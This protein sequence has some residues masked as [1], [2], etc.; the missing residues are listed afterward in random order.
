MDLGRAADRH[1]AGEISSGPISFE[2]E[3]SLAGA[4]ALSGASMAAMLRCRRRQVQRRPSRAQ[5]A[6][7]SVAEGCRV[8]RPKLLET[9]LQKECFVITPSAN[10]QRDLSASPPPPKQT[11]FRLASAHTFE[12]FSNRGDKAV[13]GETI[14]SSGG[15]G[16]LNASVGSLELRERGVTAGRLR[17]VWL[18]CGRDRDLYQ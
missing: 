10:E 5:A 18:R 14:R 16:W 13:V 4:A 9:F 2:E 7:A 11:V 15:A 6:A 17:D 8:P 1:H 3:S 12:G